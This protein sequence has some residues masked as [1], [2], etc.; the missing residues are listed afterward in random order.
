MKER[1]RAKKHNLDIFFSLSFFSFFKQSPH[2]QRRL[3]PFPRLARLWP[4]AGA[5]VLMEIEFCFFLERRK[6]K[7]GSE[8]LFSLSFSIPSLSFSLLSSSSVLPRPQRRRRVHDRLHL[9]PGSGSSRLQGSSVYG[10]PVPGHRGSEGIDDRSEPEPEQRGLRVGAAGDED[11]SHQGLGE[12][13]G[14]RGILEERG[15]EREKEASYIYKKNLFS[16]PSLTWTLSPCGWML[17]PV[18]AT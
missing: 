6:R 13:E 15:R 4:P 17:P 8:F 14:L 5:P 12:E 1:F 7:P 10:S 18:G 2:V 16:F 11:E 3:P 9:G